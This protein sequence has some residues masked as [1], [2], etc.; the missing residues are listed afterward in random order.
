VQ[1][2][3]QIEPQTVETPAESAAPVAVAS[4]K[5]GGKPAGPPAESKVTES[6]LGEIKNRLGKLEA[7]LSKVLEQQKDAKLPFVALERR[8]EAI[9]NDMAGN[10]SALG[11]A[12]PSI[13]KRLQAMVAERTKADARILD[14]VS[15]YEASVQKSL[16][17]AVAS[18]EALTGI[19]PQNAALVRKVIGEL[20]ARTAPATSAQRAEAAPTRPWWQGWWAVFAVAGAVVVALLALLG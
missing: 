19:T 14:A 3:Q 7:L 15:K 11:T 6:Q 4:G 17:A 10:I 9:T 18:C 20:K 13:E 12:V 8:V 16:E 5:K 1:D 2:E